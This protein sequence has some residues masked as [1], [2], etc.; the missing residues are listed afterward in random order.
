MYCFNSFLD[1]LKLKFR[2][3]G[4]AF[5]PSVWFQGCNY[6]ARSL[7]NCMK[8]DVS[9]SDGSYWCFHS[10]VD[11]S[12]SSIEAEQICGH[13]RLYNWESLA[14]PPPNLFFFAPKISHWE[15]DIRK[16]TLFL[17]QFLKCDLDICRWRK[18]NM[19]WSSPASFCCAV[20]WCY[21]PAFKSIFSYSW[22]MVCQIPYEKQKLMAQVAPH[23]LDRKEGGRCEFKAQPIHRKVFL[24]LLGP[25]NLAV[26]QA[27]PG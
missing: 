2:N 24:N 26:R 11:T 10:N 6:K 21:V 18:G 14:S 8:G 1:V 16:R 13:N 7:K 3:L 4:L 23:S 27:W 15:N 9:W 5:L 22:S 25:A 20:L 19:T 17:L 12:C